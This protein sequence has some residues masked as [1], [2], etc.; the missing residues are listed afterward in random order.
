MRQR[1]VLGDG[2]QVLLA[3]D[4]ATMRDACRQAL[5]KLDLSIT[6]AKNGNQALRLARGRAFDLVILDLKMP[7]TPGMEVLGALKQENP[8]TPV[9][10]ITGYATIESAVEAIRRGA[11]DFL[12]KP[13]TPETLR[14][15]V[16]RVLASSHLQRE[17]VY[18]KRTLDHDA[19]KHRMVGRSKEINAVRDLI[20]RV[21]PTDS[22]VLITGESGTGKELVARAIH[23]H[24]ARSSKPF[25]TVDCCTLVGTLFES[26]LFGHVRG[27]FTG[28]T[29]TTHG[30]F[31][32]ANGGT[33]FFDE[34]GN[35]SPDIQAKLLRAI[36]EREFTR[37]GSSQTI[38]VDIRIVAATNRDLLAAVREGTFREDL[39]YRLGVVPITLPP[40]RH[41]R[42]DIPELAG[43][44]VKR[45]AKERKK[46]VKG[47]S[48]EAMDV[49][50]DSPWPGN[51]RELENAIERAVIL[52]EGDVIEPVDLLQYGFR[53]RT[54]GSGATSNSPAE[55]LPLEEVERRHIEHVLAYTGGNRGRAAKYLGVDRKTLW[56]K[57]KK[58]A[59]TA[60]ARAGPQEADE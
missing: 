1:G 23:N 14:M 43:F 11:D 49:L 57:M 31:E 34:I 47:I 38:R 2:T 46:N 54:P 15:L 18:L 25:V 33:L 59:I 42:E 36:Q 26:E 51:V 28:A 19:S 12:P 40:L 45:Y 53:H 24:S 48:P 22:T 6:E 3:D 56:R 37:V 10:I 21:A 13:F 7:G 30:R 39:Y 9:I 41:H 58:Y 32:F 20:R 27:S 5:A 44:F 52:A 29:A 17:N 50:V 8:A 55:I 35:V 60:D 16:Q 4:E